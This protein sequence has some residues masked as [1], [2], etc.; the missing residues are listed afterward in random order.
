M[1]NRWLA[2]YA[3]HWRPMLTFRSRREELAEWAE[4]NADVRAALDSR[5]VFGVGIGH[6]SV[7][8]TAGTHSLDLAIG[9]PSA[10]VEH[11][12]GLLVAAFE[13]L[14]PRSFHVAAARLA[15][16][17]ELPDNYEVLR[18]RL[19][20]RATGNLGGAGEPVDCA[21]RADLR[22]ATG[23]VQV[24]FGVVDR[25]ELRQN[26]TEP[27]DET[28]PSLPRGEDL[29]E[30]PSASLLADVTWMASRRMTLPEDDSSAALWNY[31]KAVIH[32]A[33]GETSDI[34]DALGVGLEAEGGDHE[35]SRGA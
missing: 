25:N 26:L 4:R 35:L 1:A 13:I 24:S 33:N 21:V 5:D 2:A 16:T 32:I 14:K 11:L 34:V 29:G 7:R 30:L 9:T 28:S 23:D 17:Y 22:T 10:D 6:P 3:F 18:S 27:S 8:V 12:R 15:L 19:A 20:R 31:V